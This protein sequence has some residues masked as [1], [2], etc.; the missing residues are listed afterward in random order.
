M[1]LRAS[2][3]SLLLMP[4]FLAGSA[5]AQCEVTKFTSGDGLGG[6]Q[7]G[8]EVAFSGDWAV[9]GAP[10]DDEGG[11]DRGA[12]FV[13]E[14]V[15]GAW[16]ER[17]KLTASDAEDLDFFGFKVAIDADTIAVTAL[18]DGFDIGSV[19]VFERPA[20]GMDFTETAKLGGGFVGEFFG[21]GLELEGDTLVVGAC[22]VSQFLI[23]DIGKGKVTVF[24]RTGSSWSEE[25]TL[26]ASD[27]VDGDAFGASVSLSGNRLL[28]GAEGAPGEPGSGAAYV[29][30]RPDA[31]SDFAEVEKLTPSDGAAEDFFGQSCALD[32]DLAVLGSPQHEGGGAPVDSGA[33]YVFEFDGLDWNETVK[34]APAVPLSDDRY[35]RSVA[36]EGETLVV[37]AYSE[38]G[39]TT[40]RA[41]VYDR[42]G[43]S[44]GE[45]AQ[46]VGA[47]S[48]VADQ[49]GHGVYLASGR[50]LVGARLDDGA[51]SVYEF[52]ATVAAA[53]VARLGSVPNPD[54]LKPGVT[55]AP[56]LGGVWDPVIDHTTFEPGAI[57]DFLIVSV[58]PIDAPL[59]AP[60][61]T[62]LCNLPFVATLTNLVPGTP[63]ALPMPTDCGLAG[64]T[65]CAQGGSVRPDLALVLANALDFTLGNY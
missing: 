26:F 10:T 1:H 55:G 46:Y 36:L 14:R 37:G 22:E 39:T 42:Q 16:V 24:E 17:Q 63:F 58:L 35:G 7:F 54:A 51:G 32:G 25:Q 65:L 33:V 38:A 41:F 62:L 60:T 57:G 23:F 59:G 4:V 8:S 6:D 34:L 19:Y 15:G 50:V 40:G 43:G 27:G 47:D 20:P 49:F 2:V 48:V 44:W 3:L 21:I 31:T 29:F 52:E 11:S 28:V 53:E 61:G 56:V 30:E 12:A 9:V 18:F 45:T 5:A 64:V 13:F